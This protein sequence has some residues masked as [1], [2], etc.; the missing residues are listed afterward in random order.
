VRTWN[1]WP[2][3]ID[4]SFICLWPASSTWGGEID[5][6]SMLKLVVH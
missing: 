3:P 5:S 1:E 4:L 2:T 6:L